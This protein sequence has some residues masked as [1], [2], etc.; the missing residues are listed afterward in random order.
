MLVNLI[1]SSVMLFHPIEDPSLIAQPPPESPG[2][3][4]SPFDAP[5]DANVTAFIPLYLV[6]LIVGLF[7]VLVV[8]HQVHT[9]RAPPPHH[10]C[11][12]SV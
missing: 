6:A 4:P 3:L 9:V 7:G 1:V 2:E 10:P 8:L 5:R 12:R 11:H